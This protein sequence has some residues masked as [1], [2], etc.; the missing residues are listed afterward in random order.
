MG[1]GADLSL[2]RLRP[3]LL[4]CLACLGG[5]VFLSVA[6]RGLPLL[7]SPGSRPHLFRTLGW[8]GRTPPL[9]PTFYKSHI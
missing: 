6:A 2:K 1:L 9:A 8:A 4:P 5:A 7:S 3:H